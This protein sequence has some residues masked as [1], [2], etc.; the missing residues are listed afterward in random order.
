M[1]PLVS[2]DQMQN[3]DQ[4]TIAAGTDGFVLMRRAGAA[5]AAVLRGRWSARPVLVLTGPGQN[6]GDGWIVADLLARAGWPVTVATNWAPS[7]LKGDAH[8]A[9]ARAGLSPISLTEA[10]SRPHTLVVDALFGAG[11]SRPIKG[12]PAAIINAVKEWGAAVIAADLP[13]GLDGRTGQIHGDA[14]T[15]SATVT[16]G[17]AK[18]GHFIGEGLSLCGDL[19]IADI[20]LDLRSDDAAAILN[21]PEAWR[22]DLPWPPRAAHKYD[23]GGVLVLA[24]PRHQTGAARLCA[25]AAARAGAGAVTLACRPSAADI[26]A[27]HET[28]ALLAILREDDDLA[29]LCRSKRVKAVAIGPGLGMDEAARSA[30]RTILTAQIPAVLDADAL[31]LIARDRSLRERLGCH[32]VLTPHEGEFSRLFPDWEGDALS[33]C[34]KAADELGTTLLLKGAATVIATPG[35]RPVINA[36][37][38]P[39]LATAGSG[40]VLTGII[41]GLIAQDMPPHNA[42]CAGAWLHGEGG[43][44][45]DP[46]LTAEDLPAEVG[47]AMAAASQARPQRA[48]RLGQR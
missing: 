35:A 29:A 15:A 22:Q 48:R 11:L 23:R 41:A 28:A 25:E 8:R 40:D 4:R 31:T 45:A 13:S 16:F 10:L 38:S 46:G 47:A 30:L 33:R 24:G 19:H 37:A 7:T 36:H 42:A 43:L 26:I 14:L 6:G 12:P 21:H 27:G 34:A 20:G 3:V 32:H 18:P 17:A 44:A 39:V 9:A 5:I 1:I 2:P